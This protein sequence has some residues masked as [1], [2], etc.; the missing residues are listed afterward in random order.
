MKCGCFCVSSRRRHSRCAL[1]TGVQTWAL[2]ISRN[3]GD[4][5]RTLRGDAWVD[6][7]RLAEVLGQMVQ[8]AA[9][10]VS[11]VGLYNVP[12]RLEIGINARLDVAVEEIG[13]ASCRERVWKY[14]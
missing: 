14:V 5:V 13:R 8:D 11:G 6:A 10:E 1:V 12:G 4:D 2:P 3:D 9:N 7:R